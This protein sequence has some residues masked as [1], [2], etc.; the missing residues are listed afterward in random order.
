M[1]EP[2]RAWNKPMLVFAWVC[3]GLAIVSL[4][5]LVVDQRMLDG[6]PVW[7]KPLKFAI[8]GLV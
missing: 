8:S 4:A 2:Y 7:V 1:S 6:A 5:G 3:A